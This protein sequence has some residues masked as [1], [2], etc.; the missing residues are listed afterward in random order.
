MCAT[1]SLYRHVALHGLRALI[2]HQRALVDNNVE[3]VFARLLEA[4]RN[5]A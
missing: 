3:I 4:G 5:A 1:P 2:S